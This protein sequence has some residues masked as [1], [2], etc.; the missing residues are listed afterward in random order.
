MPLHVDECRRCSDAGIYV[1]DTVSA[2]NPNG[3]NKYLLTYDDR[4]ETLTSRIASLQSNT[5]KCLCPQA[6]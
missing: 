6:T 2:Q 1:V 4:F 3:S 5:G